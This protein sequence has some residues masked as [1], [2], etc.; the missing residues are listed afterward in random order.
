MYISA[1]YLF[2]SIYHYFKPVPGLFDDEE[3]KGEKPENS[4]EK[5]E[6]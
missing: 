4:Q 2:Q 1:I 5:P 3:D 6:N